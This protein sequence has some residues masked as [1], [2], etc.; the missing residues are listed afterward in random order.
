[1]IALAPAVIDS[2]ARYWLSYIRRP[3]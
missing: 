1:M 3:R 2:I